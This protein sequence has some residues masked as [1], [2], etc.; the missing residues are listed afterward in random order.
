MSKLI[1]TFYSPHCFIIL[2]S[3]CE[4]K[5]YVKQAV[6]SFLPLQINASKML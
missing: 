3:S 5:I 2:Y 6:I 4:A 1:T